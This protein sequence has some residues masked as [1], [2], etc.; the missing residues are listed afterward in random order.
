MA[1]Y[2]KLI[3]DKIVL[4]TVSPFVDCHTSISLSEF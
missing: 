3:N 2:E 1:I 4:D